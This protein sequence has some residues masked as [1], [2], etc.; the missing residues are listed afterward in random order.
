[1]S[2]LRVKLKTRLQHTEQLSDYISAIAWSPQTQILASCSAAGELCLSSLNGHSVALHQAGE[3]ALNCLDFSAEGNFLA[4]AG[5]AGTLEI[6][7]LQGEIPTLIWERNYPSTWLDTLQWHPQKSLLAYAVGREVHI[8]DLEQDVIIATLPF[9]NSSI[10]DLSWHPKQD[11]LAVSGDGGVKVWNLNDLDS[12]PYQLEVPGASLT[13]AWSKEGN[14]LASGNLDRTLSILA[15]DNPPP[16]LMQGFPGKVRKLAWSNFSPDQS[17]QIATACLEGIIIWQQEKKGGQWQNTVLENHQGFVRDLSFHPSQP[18]LASASDDG[19]II[20]WQDQK[21]IKTL[22][23]ETG[24]FSSLQW[25]KQ[26]NYLAAGTSHG[27]VLIWELVSGEKLKK[28]F[29]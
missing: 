17:P 11:Y 14:Y 9:E 2:S 10:F 3:M 28:G 26:G 22:K 7:N 29:G 23:I 1:M 18:I 20:L 25:H 4:T 5:Q 16:W 21:S 8:L 13:V 27:E 12:S 6:W 19:R 24:G 15:W